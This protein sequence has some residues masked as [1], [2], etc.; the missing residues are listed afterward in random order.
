MSGRKIVKFI[1]DNDQL[2]RRLIKL[3]PTQYVKISLY[4]LKLRLKRMRAIR[5][6]L[7]PIPMAPRLKSTVASVAP[8]GWHWKCFEIFDVLLDPPMPNLRLAPIIATVQT[9]T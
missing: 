4:L 1:N 9:E 3:I 5:T 7:A 6:M 2:Q 8:P